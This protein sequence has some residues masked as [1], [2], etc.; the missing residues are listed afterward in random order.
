M[1][2]HKN[3]RRRGWGKRLMGGGVTEDFSRAG[4]LLYKVPADI[5]ALAG[6]AT[7][8]SFI[9]AEA[10][11]NLIGSESGFRPAKNGHGIAQLLKGTYL[12]TAYE[13]HH[14]LRKPHADLLKSNIEKKNIA[15]KGEDPHYVYRIKKGGE[16]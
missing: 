4:G 16:T 3:A 8:Q 12:Q 13:N 10:A 11:L 6:R 2:A 1:Y 7:G 15:P 9:P 14:V 5:A